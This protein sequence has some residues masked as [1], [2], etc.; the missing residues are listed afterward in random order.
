MRD[1]TSK[2]RQA[3]QRSDSD[4]RALALLESDWRRWTRAL[5]PRH[6]V[7]PFVERHEQFWDWVW[8]IER[9]TKPAP[10]VAI[11]GRGGAKSASAEASLAALGARRKRRYALYVSGTQ[12]QAE[13]HLGNVASLLL[14]PVFAQQYPGMSE[15][16][17]NTFGAAAGW[18]K[19]QLRTASGFTIDCIGL[20]VAS[21]GF[22]IDDARPD[23]IILDDIDS[24]HDSARTVQ[25]KIETIA[26][27]ILPTGA[28]DCATL[29]IQ[30]I[31]HS[32]SIA[33]RFVDGTSDFL[34]D[35]QLSGPY[36]AVDGLAVESRPIGG[37]RRRYFI[38]GGTATW[39][40]QPLD[41]CE[42]QINEWG[43]QAFRAEAQHERIEQAGGLFSHIEYRHTSR[44]QLP[45]LVRVVVWVDPAVSNTDESDCMAISV[46]GIDNDGIVYRLYSWEQRTSPED[47]IRR[48]LVVAVEYGSDT[49]GVETDQGGDTWLSVY[50]RAAQA[51]QDELHAAGVALPYLPRFRAAKAG[52]FG[53]K[54]HRSS[55][56]VGDYERGE[57]VHVL[58][59]HEA[60]EHALYRFPKVKPF[61]LTDASFW[62]WA[63]LRGMIPDDD[64]GPG[65]LLS[66][67]APGWFGLGSGDASA[68]TDLD[69]DEAGYP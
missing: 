46:A 25:K 30:N 28:N 3:S 20:D 27:D 57:I 35:H 16:L 40:G 64:E 32:K 5:F 54:V 12:V 9:G 2:R 45:D 13:K 34:I 4:A 63:D 41:V 31:V 50:Y 17:I 44:A 15:R 37:G 14:S 68:Y 42:E 8:S 59:T 6:F 56:M 47:A 39:P 62:S 22:K 18:R 36:P 66:G 10:F 67:G 1:Y 48:A 65:L 55:Q 23:V 49:I 51:L 24:K 33:A 52:S 38:V 11:W 43:L 21:R 58:G 69:G 7:A 19:N 53:S 26:E 60:L 61:D 29:F